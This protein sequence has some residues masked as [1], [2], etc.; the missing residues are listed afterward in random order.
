MVLKKY[1]FFKEFDLSPRWDPNK[2]Y[3]SVE[4]IGGDT[5]ILSF[6]VVHYTIN[7]NII[8]YYSLPDLKKIS[9]YIKKKRKNSIS[10][11]HYEFISGC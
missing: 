2:Y 8:E 7:I 11:Y 9:F 4:K 1:I 10:W 5:K 6:P 3:H